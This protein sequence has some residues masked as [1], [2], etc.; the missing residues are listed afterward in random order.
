MKNTKT[1][2]KVLSGLLGMAL[3]TGVLFIANSFVGNPISL[4]LANQVIKEY[5]AQNYSDLELELNK[6]HY[7]FKLGGY[8]ALAESPSS[9]DTHF[10]VFYRNGKVF[11]DSYEDNVLSKYNTLSR[12]EDEYNRLVITLLAEI[13]G[14]ENNRARVQIGK[15]EY[16]NPKV[17]L[18]MPFDKTL[19]ID[20]NLTVKIELKDSSMAN[21]ADLFENVHR[22]MLKNGFVFQSYEVFSEHEATLVMISNV[23]PVDIESGELEKRLQDALNYKDEDINKEMRI[24]KDNPNPFRD[25]KL[26]VFIKD[27][28][29]TE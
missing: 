4:F 7:D 20:M 17:K 9:I 6:A 10:Y 25:K 21:M 22:T 12:L 18:D 28:N 15:M 14:L 2:S 23:T 24:T 13:P 1:V 26:T 5:T 8:S 27:A 19:P 3:I 29:T 11:R 16:N